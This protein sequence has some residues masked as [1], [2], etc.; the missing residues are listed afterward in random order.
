MP[1]SLSDLDPS[2]LESDLIESTTNAHSYA[3]SSFPVRFTVVEPG[4]STE[5]SE[6][7]AL[8]NKFLGASVIMQ[9]VESMLPAVG[10]R[11][12]TQNRS[13]GNSQAVSLQL[14]SLGEGA[15]PINS[16]LPRP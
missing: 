15:R 10:Q 14:Q 16:Y 4:D 5:D 6:A 12:Q 13:N 1:S 9:G 3:F 7:R 11:Q 2:T 8:L